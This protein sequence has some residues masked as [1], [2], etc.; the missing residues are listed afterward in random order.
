MIVMGSTRQG[1]QG[2]R[3]AVC[4]ADPEIRSRIESSLV[5]AGHEV[6]A[7]GSSPHE[8]IPYARQLEPDVIVLGAV[9]EPFS[10]LR[11]VTAVRAELPEIP[12]VVVAL[13]F[14]TRAARK[15]VRADVDGLLHE[16]DLEAALPATIH[17]VLADQLCIPASL[18]GALARPVFSHR[19][20]QV[21]E[22]VVAGLSNSE[23]ASRLYLSESTVK[24]HLAA[25]FRKLGVSSRGEAARRA[26]DPELGLEL[27]SSALLEAQP[28]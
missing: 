5:L 16:T 19:E 4:A 26:T 22:L 10:P 8:L 20:K 21:L 23:I 1:Q 7:A 15:L 28:L 14:F 17:A 3:I 18:R 13:G 2:S 27:S 25:S 24:S 9:L 12:L 6:I 11:D